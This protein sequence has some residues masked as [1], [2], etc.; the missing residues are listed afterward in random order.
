M[1]F[2]A[3]AVQQQ[4]EEERFV[5]AVAVALRQRGV[6]LPRLVRAAPHLDAEV[7]DVVL[8][9]ADGGGDLR[10]ARRVL[11][12]NLRGQRLHGGERFEVRLEEVRRPLRYLA[13]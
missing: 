8:H 4:G 11:A 3:E 10:V 13:P 9:E 7:A 2:Q 6:R 12:A 5:L 1:R